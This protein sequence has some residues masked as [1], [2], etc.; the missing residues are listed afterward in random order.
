VFEGFEPEEDRFAWLIDHA[1]GWQ[2]GEQGILIALADKIAPSG[3]CVEIGA[4]DGDLLP[5][6]I[7]PFYERGNECVLFEA[8]AESLGSLVLKYPKATH[9]GRFVNGFES[10]I[11]NCPAVCVIDVDG[12]DSQIM[13]N[14]LANHDPHVLM[15]EHF[16]KCH[17]ADCD[18]EGDIPYW[19]LGQ[20]LP[21]NFRIQDNAATINSIAA[22][23]EYIRVGTTRVNSIF[24]HKCHIN[25]V[26]Q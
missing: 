5:L 25:R 7:H 2:F 24:V 8:D 14:I 19:L 6:T 9:R 12:I 22:E 23:N 11:C 1:G 21:D 16:D 4:G 3:Q 17:P 18:T 20:H 26:S 15:V 13:Q 10:V